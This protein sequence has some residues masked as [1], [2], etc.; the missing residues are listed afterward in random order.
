MGLKKCPICGEKFADTYKHCPFCEEDENP[1]KAKH[2]KRYG[3]G[4]GG[5][6]LARRNYEEDRPRPL[7]DDEAPSQGRR[8]HRDDAYDDQEESYQGR[9][10]RRDDTY[11]DQE[12]A[13]QGRRSAGYDDGYDDYD[14]DDRG[15]PWFKIVMV[16]LLAIIIACVLYLGRG[17][18]GSLLPAGNDDPGQNSSMMDSDGAQS[19]NEDDQT[20]DPNE[21][22]VPDVTDPDSGDTQD[23]TQSQGGTED[24]NSNDSNHTSVTGT[25]TLSHE[26]VSIAGDE[27]FTLSARS[28]SGDVTY[29]SADPSIATVSSSG[30]VTGVKKGTTKI[31]VTRGSDSAECIVRVKSDGKGASSGGSTATSASASLNRE[32]MTLAVNE[33]FSLKVSGVSG[34]S[35][36][37]ANAAVATVDGSGKVTGVK[38][39]T[40]KVTASW[41]GGSAT[42][43]VRVK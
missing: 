25:L 33:S 41:S 20:T 5:R 31:T 26:D 6:R 37:T 36:S 17:V 15:S 4:E 42:C 8:S 1:R 13:Y 23:D 18:I 29:T 35:W 22:T 14:G 3:Y 40:T 10:S 7:Y 9:R 39:G 43:I 38:S 19:D 28:G 24:N 30:V 32:D 21:G 12:E 34:V 11:D 2:P 27:S 16:I